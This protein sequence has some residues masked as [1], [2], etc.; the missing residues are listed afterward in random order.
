[1]NTL[2]NN[3]GTLD[4]VTILRFAHAFESGGGTERYLDDLDH[5][6]L[7]RNAMTIV[8]LHLTRRSSGYSSEELIGKGRLVRIALRVLPGNDRHPNGDEN[9]FRFRLKRTLRDWVVYNP[10]VWPAIGASWIASLR[11][12]HEPG[13]AVGAGDAAAAV[14]RN[15]R[16]NLAVLHFFGGADAEEVMN[17]ARKVR[18][19]IAIQNHF[20]NDRFQHLAIRKHA[21]SADGVA[22]VNGLELPRYVRNGFMNLSDGI[23]TEF[24][25]RENARPLENPPSQPVILLPAR[26]VREKGQLD[27][28]H[29]AALLRRSGVECCLAF[30]GRADSS[31]FVNELSQTI[32][33][34]GLNEHVRFLGDLKLEELRDWYAASAVVGLPTCH[35]EGLPRIVLEAQS[36]GVPVVAYN[37]GGVADGIASGRTGY[38]LPTG[39]IPGLANR[40]REILASASLR[41]HMGTCGREAAVTRFSLAALAGRHEQFYLRIISDFAARKKMKRP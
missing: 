28:V 24:F 20:S 37:T 23:D 5:V 26:V 22:G 14:F 15:R 3:C 21:M 41:A 4:G 38:L 13:Q 17:E 9:Q 2:T 32:A 12:T 7:A 6:L 33:S 27:L 40:L 25:R 8:R 16:V 36:M 31:S 34:T 29:A 19:P 18:V 35:H 39:D 1:M 30:A 11:L 10:L